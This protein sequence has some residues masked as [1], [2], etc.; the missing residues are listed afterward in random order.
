MFSKMTAQTFAGSKNLTA[1]A[2]M[3]V[4][5]DLTNVIPITVA[6][7]ILRDVPDCSYMSRVCCSPGEMEITLAA[8]QVARLS[9]M[10]L[11]SF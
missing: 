4:Q 9:L 1:V 11:E 8:V 6:A 3:V 7:V 2:A 5:R 10:A